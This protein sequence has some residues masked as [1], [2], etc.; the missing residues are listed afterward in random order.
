MGLEWLLARRYLQSNKWRFL[1]S[2]ATVL[3]IFGIA[4]GVA[5]LVSVMSVMNGF[6]ARLLSSILGMNG[7][8]TV[9]CA[10]A[11]YPSVVSEVKQIPGVVVAAPVIEGQAMIK[12][13][14]EVMGAVVRG[15]NMQD[16]RSKLSGYIVRGNMEMLEEGLILGSRLAD[17]IRT[18]YGSEVTIISPETSSG[19]F[20]TVPRTKTYKVVG[21]FD[22]GV[23][24]Y[25]SAFA[26]IPLRD[27]QQLFGY[28][29]GVRCIEV[30]LEDAKRSSEILG[31]IAEKTGLR[32]EDWKAQQGQYFRALELESDAMFFILTLIVIVA[33][34][35]IIS[36]VSILVRDK[37]G[38][39]AIMR[40]MGMSRCAIMRI[41]CMCGAFTGMIG[42][43]IGC[44]IGIVFATNVEGINDLLRLVGGGTLLESIAYCLDGVLPEMVLRDVVKV[45]SLS[46]GV[47]LAAA[48]PPAIGAACQNPV[49]VL[50]YE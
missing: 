23:Q 18:D 9:H 27:S 8:I 13:G 41:F 17:S 22:V 40:T 3:S 11:H 15:M 24:E 26:Y 29:D 12:C 33:A 10:G 48:V 39:V 34:F 28:K 42:T 1:F 16:I 36:G 43:S 47:S 2:T 37:K 31:T 25:D 14:Q 46:M 19:M 7:H 45:A 4:I 32:V 6:S 5:T 30:F 44:C 50:K 35:N 38:A 20:G 49:D 21:I